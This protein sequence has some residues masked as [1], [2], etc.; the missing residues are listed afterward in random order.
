M[1]RP[2]IL[3][4][5][6]MTAVIVSGLLFSLYL[7]S[8]ISSMRNLRASIEDFQKKTQEDLEKKPAGMH[9]LKE[10]FP[11]AGNTA[12][13]IENAYRIAKQ[14]GIQDMIFEQKRTEFLD[15]ASGRTFKALPVSGQK[16]KVISVYPVRISFHSG[17]RN[18]AEFIREVQDQ[19]RMV[20]IESLAVKR[21]TGYLSVDMVMNI[22]ATG[23]H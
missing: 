16:P 22:Y 8:K 23:D 9:N 4:L 10:L 14:R 18:M 21:D 6:I 5:L 19:P 1:N 20:T 12:G 17:Y 3:F 11:A 15:S 7:K 2:K 13:F